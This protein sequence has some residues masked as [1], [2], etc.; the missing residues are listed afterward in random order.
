[1]VLSALF[2]QACHNGNGNVHTA[3]PTDP[4]DSGITAADTG[5]AAMAVQSAMMEVTLGNIA[6][7]RAGDA[8]VKAFGA[9]MVKDHSQANDMLKGIADRKDIVLADSLDQD[10]HSDMDSLSGRSNADFDD[11][12]INR[13]VQAHEAD[14]RA[15]EKGAEQIT[16]PDIKGFIQTQ[17]PVLKMHLD[18]ARAIQRDLEQ[19]HDASLR[20]RREPFAS[21]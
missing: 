20:S 3:D 16:D 6:Q 4:P 1:M 13:M 18:S 5:F 21:H 11:A 14:I 17:L 19:Q 15:F 9:M 12:Y 7:Q 10:H 8:R 2:L